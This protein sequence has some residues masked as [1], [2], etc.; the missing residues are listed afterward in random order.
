MIVLHDYVLVRPDMPAKKTPGGLI[1]PD[2]AQSRP[3]EGI[4]VGHGPGQMTSAGVLAPSS[5]R[6]GDRVRYLEQCHNLTEWRVDD[7][8]EKLVMLRETDVV[9]VLERP[10]SAIAEFVVLYDKLSKT[11]SAP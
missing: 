4:V 9:A 6:E 2:E 7:K 10:P 1:L 11:R 3:C 5:V 8:T